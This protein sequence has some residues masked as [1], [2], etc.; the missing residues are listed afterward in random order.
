M[1]DLATLVAR[2]GAALH[3]AGLPAGPDRS[4]RFARSVVVA[5]PRTVEGLYCCALA[6]LTSDPADVEVL[7]RVFG[8]VFG[9]LVDAAEWRG[10]RRPG[11]EGN[12]PAAAAA[13]AV[14]AGV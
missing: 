14:A 4:E 3:D 11:G 10:D 9:G 8:A 12:S 5:G 1:A 7:D 13:P 2:F 6:T